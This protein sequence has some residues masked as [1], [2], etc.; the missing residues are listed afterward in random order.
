[1]KIAWLTPLSHRSAIGRVSVGVVRALLAKKHEVMVIRSERDRNSTEATH[2]VPTQTVWWHD[3]S[4]T[5]IELQNDAIVLNFGD[6][7]DFHAGTLAFVDKV[8]CI[9]IFHDFYLYSFFNR[10]LAHSG[11]DENVHHREVHYTYG[12]GARDLASLAWQNVASIERIAQEIPMTEWLASRCGAALAHSQ[13]YQWRLAHSC[14]GPIA[15]APLCYDARAVDP[16]PERRDGLVTITTVGVI[17]PNKCVD[18]LIKSIV[19]SPQLLEKCCV[20]L[21]GPITPDERSKIEDLCKHIG[22]DK[23]SIIGEVEE[24]VLIEE[25]T[26]ADI[27]SCLRNPVLEGASASA[28][29]GLKAGRPL[30]VAN[31]G[32]YADLPDEIVFKVPAEV[33]VASLTKALET[34]VDDENLRRNMGAKAKSWASNRFTGA[35]YVSILE[36][37]FAEF[38][39]AKPPLR[40][41]RQ[42]G[43]QLAALGI[44]PGTL[45]IARISSK[46]AELFG[47]AN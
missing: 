19:S 1:M 39:N 22:F 37:L 45:P 10:W 3:I 6:N 35:A 28:I 23:L 12:D 8:P 34:L 38:I 41:G 29:E 2:S 33:D 40:V 14:P 44:E 11:L 30:I 9:G 36:G 31:A 27:L 26:R 46:M 47:A 5:D 43:E 16:L 24:A 17:N 32:F 13:F 7:Y 42:V 21:V 25:L 4:P 20:R 18:T 15:V